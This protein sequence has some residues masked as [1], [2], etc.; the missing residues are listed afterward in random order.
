MT[1][2][3]SS[4][5]FVKNIPSSIRLVDFANILITIINIL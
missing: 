1:D 5:D 2:F 4:F 3:N